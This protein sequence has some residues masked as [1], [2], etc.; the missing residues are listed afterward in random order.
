MNKFIVIIAAVLSING[1]SQ[2]TFQKTVIGPT[3]TVFYASHIDANGNIYAG[4]IYGNPPSPRALISK[5][6]EC[7]TVVWTTT[8]GVNDEEVM[9]IAESSNGNIVAVGSSNSGGL[10]G[11]VD[12]LIFMLDTAGNVQWHKLFGG[13]QHDEFF[14]VV[15][16][17]NNEFMAVGT[18][19]S[20]GLGASDILVVK[21]NTNGDTL[22]TK[23][24]GGLSVE[25]GYNIRILA[26]NNLLITGKTWTF[27]Q[28][29]GGGASD[30]YLLKINQ[31]GDI[32]WTKTLGNASFFT[33]SAFD[34]IE[35]QSGNLIVVGHG[36]GAGLTLVKL[37]S[38]GNI[39]STNF[40]INPLGGSALRANEFT[41]VQLIGN[42]TLVLMIQGENIIS[43]L[44]GPDGALILFDTTG[45]VIIS[46][47]YGGSITDNFGS[48]T[49]KN[50]TLVVVGSTYSSPFSGY[51]VKVNNAFNSGCSQ[52]THNVA[53][54]PITFLEGNGGFV[55]QG[56]E[57]GT[58]AMVINDS[59]ILTSST[60][61]A[62]CI[63]T[64]GVESLNDEADITI[65]PNPTASELNITTELNIKYVAILDIT[66][67]TIEA[68][69]LKTNAI[70]VTHLAKGIYFLKLETEEGAI[71][72]KFVKQ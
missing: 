65:Y 1:Y 25:E 34:A 32:I 45:N 43:S 16:T 26:D 15:S 9:D 27:G 18:T 17:G 71:T 62:N 56:I 61:C 57:T 58:V 3:A 67:K 12:G 69:E 41:D 72:K 13:N 20:Y 48:M 10:G 55:A 35:L 50:N 39:L 11:G 30:M 47:A 64:V 29:G 70:N 68:Y 66:G 42:D 24:Y 44:S 37:T 23:T 5:F 60:I 28:G 2:N 63:V 4:G 21:F 36:G 7:G 54:Q 59:I 38:I 49:L 53:G 22:W 40:Y 52:T 46:H 8:I 14:K 6:N 33:E 19:S 31:N 51:I